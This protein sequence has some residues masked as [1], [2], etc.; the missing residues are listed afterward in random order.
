MSAGS[1]FPLLTLCCVSKCVK[2]LLEASASLSWLARSHL[3]CSF[4]GHAGAH[5]PDAGRG[6]TAGLSVKLYFRSSRADAEQLKSDCNAVF[7]WLAQVEMRARPTEQSASR[8]RVA[9]L[10]QLLHEVNGKRESV[11]KVLNLGK[12]IQAI[13]HPMVEQ[14]VQRCL[15][16]L[17]TRYVQASQMVKQR[18]LRSKSEMDRENELDIGLS[19]LLNWVEKMQAKIDSLLD[20][21]PAVNSNTSTSN[22]TVAELDDQHR[23]FAELLE[24]QLRL[25]MSLREREPAEE[26]QSC[27]SVGCL[28]ETVAGLPVS[29]STTGVVRWLANQKCRATDLFRRYDC[30][31]D[32][33]LSCGE[34]RE[35]ILSSHFKTN[36]AEM[37]LVVEAIDRNNDGFIDL[38]EFLQA[39]KA[40]PELLT[41]DKKTSQEIE[42]QLSLCNCRDKYR[43]EVL[44]GGCCRLAERLKLVRI[45]CSAVMACD[46]GG[47]QT[48]QWFMNKNDPCRAKG[49]TNLELRERFIYARVVFK[50]FG[51]SAKKMSSLKK[52]ANQP[53]LMMLLLP[54]LLPAVRHHLL[55]LLLLMTPVTTCH[56]QSYHHYHCHH[57]HHHSRQPPP[58]ITSQ[59]DRF[60]LLPT[61]A[62]FT[63][64]TA[65]VTRQPASATLSTTVNNMTRKKAKKRIVRRDKRST[66]PLHWSIIS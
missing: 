22:G 2:P 26:R 53:L 32:G 39:L 56:K 55:K 29:R 12:Q 43:I 4:L 50:L 62:P 40:E 1:I 7:D 11:H 15:T 59:N 10:R 58:Y 27:P 54:M 3:P 42:K 14:A 13:R 33:R 31:G 23:K 6:A 30:D 8:K 25:E 45:Y 52:L 57:H 9:S 60:A 19:S 24:R 36:K 49:R 47:W 63:T 21:L 5:A 28:A 35:A 48:F 65:V 17:E 61:T 37:N 18:L 41:D 46:G 66:W 34:F 16:A 64:S 38:A 51:C 20:S 44:P